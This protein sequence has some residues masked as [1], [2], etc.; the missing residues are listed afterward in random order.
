MR[1]PLNIAAIIFFILCVIFFVL[2][3]SSL[4]KKK[5]LGAARDFVFVL[6][7]LVLSLLF[8]VISFSIEGYKALTREE[9]AATVLIQ[10]VTQQSFSVKIIF[11]DA[12]SSEYDIDGDEFYID[13]HILKWKSIANL[14]GL[15]TFYELDRVSGR[16]TDLEDEKLKSR[17]VYSLAKDRTIDI[18][19]LRLDYPFLSFLV[20]AQY[21]SATFINVNEHKKL[22]VFVSTTGLLIRDAEN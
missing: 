11:P 1:E 18:F 7:M 22:N 17:T 15:H 10:P 4:R 3:V 21:G 20:D 13:A 5:F 19:K 9:L 2:F 16:Y 14:F 12:D 6:L 8:G